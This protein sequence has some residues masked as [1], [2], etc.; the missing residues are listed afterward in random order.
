MGLLAQQNDFSGLLQLVILLIFFAGPVIA[1]LLKSQLEKKQSDGAKRRPERPQPARSEAEEQGRDL[2]R[3]LMELD[4][5]RDAAPAEP[6]PRPRPAQRRPA[7]PLHDPDV[8]RV[9]EN[10]RE[11]HVRRAAQRR[12]ARRT[13]PGSAP[14]A[15]TPAAQG[16]ARASSKRD[17]LSERSPIEGFESSFGDV[18]SEEELERSVSAD[19]R[20]TAA[21]FP[22]RHSDRRPSAMGGAL[23]AAATGAEV[24]HRGSVFTSTTEAAVMRPEFR[25]LARPSRA[26]LR[27]AV[28]W[29]E[30]LGRPVSGREEGCG[31]RGPAQF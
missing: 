26:D 4:E 24:R 15:A 13:E 1:N 22:V 7:D 6:E 8:E 30:I 16:P 31:G 27:R 23:G 10:A 3:Q 28:L 29:S 25:R 9:E 2:W 5:E 12:A 17:P 19:H 14:T 21:A 11:R 18:P 20:A